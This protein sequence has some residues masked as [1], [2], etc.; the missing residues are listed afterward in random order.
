[1][2]K[3]ENRA[4]V[5]LYKFLKSNFRGGK[6]I[7]PANICPIVPLTFLK[8]GIG[9]LFVDID[10][11]HILDRSICLEMITKSQID[12]L[13]FVHAY[14]K[15]FDNAEFYEQVKSINPNFVIID[16]KCLCIP[17][18]TLTVKKNI[19]LELF[20]TGYS[21]YVDLSYGGWGILQDNYS[22]DMHM[23]P[24]NITEY[25]SVMDSIRNSLTLE[26]RFK[27]VDTDWLDTTPLIAKEEYLEKVHNKLEKIKQHKDEINFIY[28]DKLPEHIKFKAGYENWRFMVQISDRKKILNAIKESNLFA[29]TNFPSVAYIFNNQQMP[30]AEVYQQTN[31]NLF[32]DFRIN[33]DSAEKICEIIIKVI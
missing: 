23:L 1:M 14:G 32:N 31:I 2:V 21:K 25:I 6:F 4:T 22:Y 30:I 26:T 17:D 16:D 28:N 7:L 9:F 33:R 13:I 20:S 3:F 24:F 8:A 12:G 10:H 11:S 29:G 27:Y 15:L 19:D 5:V 18:L